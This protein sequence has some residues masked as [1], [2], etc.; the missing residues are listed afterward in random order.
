MGYS[1]CYVF[2]LDGTLNDNHGRYHHRGELTD[3]DNVNAPIYTLYL[4]LWKAKDENTEIIIATGRSDAYELDTI[5]WLD[6]CKIPYDRLAMRPHYNGQN[7]KAFKTGLFS[8]LR[9]KYDTLV[10]F[11]DRQDHAQEWRRLGFTA[12]DVSGNIFDLSW[13]QKLGRWMLG[14]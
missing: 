13:W 4:D 7:T 9:E 2:D 6:E 1:K 10:I 5:K 8:A 12:I 14:V 11:E 3:F